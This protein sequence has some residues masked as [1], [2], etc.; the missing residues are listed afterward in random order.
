M[1]HLYNTQK[2]EFVLMRRSVECIVFNKELENLA[3]IKELTDKIMQSKYVPCGLFSKFAKCAG[4]KASRTLLH[5]YSDW[6]DEQN[7]RA[8]NTEAMQALK[9]AKNYRISWTVKRN[10]AIIKELFD[11]GFGIYEEEAICDYQQGAEN[12]FMYGYLLGVTAHE[13]AV[14]A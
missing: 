8:L 14:R 13:K 11:I 7:K 6:R 12:A 4:E 5:F 2:D 9:R 1:E 10:R 3:E